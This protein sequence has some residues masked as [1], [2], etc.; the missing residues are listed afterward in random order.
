MPRATLVAHGLSFQ[1][2][3]CLH[4]LDEFGMLTQI[5]ILTHALFPLGCL[6]AGAAAYG[7][8]HAMALDTMD[9]HGMDSRG[10]WYPYGVHVAHDMALKA[11]HGALT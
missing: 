10:V 3:S 5:H 11:R 9:E 8:A 6:G 1:V 7:M 4:A 2:M